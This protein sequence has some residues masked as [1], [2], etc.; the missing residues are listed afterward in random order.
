MA[1]KNVELQLL[2]EPVRHL[3]LSDYCVVTPDTT[4]RETVEQ[5]RELRKHTAFVVGQH[6]RLQGLLTDRDVLRRIS[7]KPET[8]D[9]P[10]TEIMTKDPDTLSSRATTAD[11][12]RLMNEN[13]YRNVP[14]V[15]E[16]G[17][18]IGNVTHFAVLHY[19]SEHFPEIAFN[20]PPRPGNYAEQRDGG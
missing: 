5:M 8:W 9:Q 10:I 7:N 17:A 2:A 12:L 13:R 15:N 19:L 14:V 6:T 11:A 4:V 1:S 18:P 20:Q 3:D 16:K